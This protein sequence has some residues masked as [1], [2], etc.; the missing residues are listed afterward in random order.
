MNRVVITGLGAV[1]S[2]G[3]SEAAIV[4]ALKN[5]QSGIALQDSYIKA[6]MRCHVASLPDLSD[7]PHIDRKLRRY[8]SEPAQYAWH[9][10]Q[11]ALAMS[12]LSQDQIAHP[13]TGVILGE[14]VGSM[15]ACQEAIDTLRASGIQKVLPYMVPRIMGHTAVASLVTALHIQG[16][17]YAISSACASAAHAIGQAY[18]EIRSG[19][20]QIMLTGGAEEGGWTSAFP[21]DAMGALTLNSNAHPQIACRPFSLDRDGFVMAGGAGILILESLE[22]AQRRSATILA[23][24]V[25][26]GV[27]SDGADMVFPCPQGSARAMTMA[28]KQA[29]ISIDYVNAHATGTPHGD[30]SEINGLRAVFG[31]DIPPVSSTKGLSG[32]AIGAAGALEAIFSILMLKHGFIA[33]CATTTELDPACAIAPIVLEAREQKTRAVLSNSFGFGGTNA[34]L[35]FTNL[36]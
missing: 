17:S 5:G 3:H 1:S 8:M 23:E 13:S 20:H 25:G 32:H 31:A 30:V 4:S 2:L 36:I 21:F 34:S 28:V 6:G 7:L 16:V 15:H 10:A 19:R 22:Q 9:A 12:G 29:G 26:Y 24:I 11:S 35:V 18:E 14:G 27:S 33:G